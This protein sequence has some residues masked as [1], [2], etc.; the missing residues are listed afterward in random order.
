MN[1]NNMRKLPEEYKAILQDF[2][3]LLNEAFADNIISAVLYGSV[4]KGHSRKDSDIDI[5]LII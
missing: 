5:C 4:A 2:I 3:G 1:N